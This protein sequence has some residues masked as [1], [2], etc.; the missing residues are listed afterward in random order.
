MNYVETKLVIEYFNVKML[1]T[2][3]LNTMMNILIEEF[4]GHF[5]IEY[6]EMKKQSRVKSSRNKEGITF[7]D[8]RFFLFELEKTGNKKRRSDLEQRIINEGQK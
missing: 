3:D 6:C 2:L 8:E 5:T 1:L 4:G 7:V